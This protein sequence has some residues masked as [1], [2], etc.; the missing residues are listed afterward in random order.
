MDVADYFFMTENLISAGLM[1]MDENLS[2]DEL[3]Y[4]WYTYLGDIIVQSAQS[5]LTTQTALDECCICYESADAIWRSN[6]CK[7]SEIC[8][9]CWAIIIFTAYKKKDISK[10]SIVSSG[11]TRAGENRLSSI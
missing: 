4:L 6:L 1:T 10:V 2:V 7:H 3:V 8:N 9:S 5:Q 11:D